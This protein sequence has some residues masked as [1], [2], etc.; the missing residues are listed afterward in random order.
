MASH[1]D[2]SM[3][4]HECPIPSRLLMLDDKE[5][6]GHTT[7]PNHITVTHKLFQ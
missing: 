4:G 5:A 3:R 2:V 6:V 1:S 7:C